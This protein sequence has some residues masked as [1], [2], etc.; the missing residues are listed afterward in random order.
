MA[1][2]IIT[3]EIQ[4]EIAVL[5]EADIDAAA[6]ALLLLESLHD[7]HKQLEYLC[8]SGNHFAYCPPFEI[9]RFSEAQRRG[10]NIFILKFLD[11]YGSLPSCRILIGFHAQRSTYYA[12]ALTHRDI[13][14]S[15]SNNAFRT[16]LDRYQ[17]C[18]IPTY[19]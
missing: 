5:E 7:D 11:E 14:Y 8:V 4:K 12:L 19:R 17:Q 15:P 2:L 9:K 16:L 3:P 10:Y 18:G 13:V 6:M 1:S